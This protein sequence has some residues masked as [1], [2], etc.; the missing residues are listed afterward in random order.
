MPITFQKTDIEGLVLIIPHIFEDERGYFIKDFERYAYASNGLPIEFFEFNESKSRKGT[1][2]GLHFQQ[3]HS[4]GKLIRIIKGEV[5]DVAVDLR[6]DSPTFGQWRGFYLSE[7]NHYVLYIP[8]GF[9]HGFLALTDDVVFSYK[10][11]DVYA[12]NYDSGIR[13]DDEIIA[14]E[15][16]IEKVGGWQN[17]I[18]SEKDKKL[19]T[20]EQFR[21]NMKPIE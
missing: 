15:W 10:C 13:F 7:K 9:A 17:V 8:K 2:R 19:Q 14:V 20:F 12:P 18:T 11:T 1:I 4:Q 3:K 16:P 5:Y 6:F 21:S